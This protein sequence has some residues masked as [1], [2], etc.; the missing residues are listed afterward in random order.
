[1]TPELTELDQDA[2]DPNAAALLLD[3]GPAAKPE[4]RQD[5]ETDDRLR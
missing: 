1:M 2:D 3:P 4:D 5:E